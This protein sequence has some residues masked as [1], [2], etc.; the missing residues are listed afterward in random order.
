VE[1]EAVVS[2][3]YCAIVRIQNTDRYD[4]RDDI[5]VN[6]IDSYD[7]LMGFVAKHLPG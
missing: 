2:I 4:D 7:R 1:E 5:R 6:L 3:G